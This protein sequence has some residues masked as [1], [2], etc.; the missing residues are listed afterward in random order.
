MNVVLNMIP[1]GFDWVCVC[2]KEIGMASQFLKPN[3][4]YGQNQGLVSVM[5]MVQVTSSQP[6]ANTRGVLGQLLIYSHGD[7][8][9]IYILAGVVDGASEWV[10]LSG[11][12][13]I[14]TSLTVDTFIIAGTTITAGGDITS[15]AGDITASAG[16]VTATNGDIT[17]IGNGNIGIQADGDITIGGDGNISI[18]GTGSLNINAATPAQAAI[19]VSTPSVVIGAVVGG[20]NYIVLSNADDSFIQLDGAGATIIANGVGSSIQ[21]TLVVANGDFAQVAGTSTA[22]SNV[23]NDTQGAGALTLVSASANPGTNTGFLKFY[24]DG[25]TVAYVPYFLDIAP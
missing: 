16:S 8:N 6:G 20:F 4:V 25:N 21:G 13:G 9:D 10:S 22:M 12:A 1:I 11:G 23:R 7:L 2:F 24:I 14:F 19:E 5:P 3:V 17:I 18:L 15:T